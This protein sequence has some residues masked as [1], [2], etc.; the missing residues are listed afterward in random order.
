M[1]MLIGGWIGFCLGWVAGALFAALN[2]VQ[3]T[4]DEVVEQ[5][6]A[7]HSGHREIR[8]DGVAA[9]LKTIW[10]KRDEQV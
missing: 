2:R 8:G 6:V 7:E 4:L 1:R 10:I 9:R 5:Y 3:D